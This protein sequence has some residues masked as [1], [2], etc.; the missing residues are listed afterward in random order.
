MKIPILRSSFLLESLVV[1]QRWFNDDS[2]LKDIQIQINQNQ[3][4]EVIEVCLS[5]FSYNNFLSSLQHFLELS[6]GVPLS[7]FSC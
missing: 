3:E 4:I 5:Y 7:Q 6:E 2:N 1:S